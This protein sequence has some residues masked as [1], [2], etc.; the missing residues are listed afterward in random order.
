[1][2]T[3]ENATVINDAENVLIE[4]WMTGL[5]DKVANA[6]FENTQGVTK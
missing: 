1:M 3:I 6:I 2:D 5:H 4:E